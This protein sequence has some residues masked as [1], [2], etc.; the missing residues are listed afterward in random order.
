MN[1]DEEQVVPLDDFIEYQ[2]D[3]TI[4]RLTETKMG[5]KLKNYFKKKSN[6]T[7]IYTTKNYM[8]FNDEE[9]KILEAVEHVII[10]A[11][12]IESDTHSSAIE[13]IYT[14]FE[15]ILNYPY[16]DEHRIINLM[17]YPDDKVLQLD[18]TLKLLELIGFEN[19]STPLIF[20]L[21]HDKDLSKVLLA[22]EAVITKVSLKIEVTVL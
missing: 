22:L 7:D 9:R 19:G 12:K 11:E 14:I 3:P 13:S 6:Y 16:E 15:N 2:D 4:P 20:L 17:N 5:R 18:S 1:P 8:S 10:D 21:S